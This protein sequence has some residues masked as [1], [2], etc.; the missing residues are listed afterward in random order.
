[1]LLPGLSF[2]LLDRECHVVDHLHGLDQPLEHGRLVSPFQ[3]PVLG[4]DSENDGAILGNGR[5]TFL[6]KVDCYARRWEPNEASE[7][8]ADDEKTTR[9]CTCMLANEY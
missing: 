3:L 6:L 8:P 1:M 9:V 4:C 2:R 7:D 5:D